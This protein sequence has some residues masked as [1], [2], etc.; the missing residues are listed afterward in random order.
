MKA[1]EQ[2]ASGKGLAMKTI[3]DLEVRG[4][5]VLVRAGLN[6]PLDGTASP[7]MARSVPACRR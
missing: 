5:R 7:A 4:R 2:R 1:P 3:D 6:V